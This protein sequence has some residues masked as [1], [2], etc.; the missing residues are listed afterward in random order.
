VTLSYQYDPQQPLPDDVAGLIFDCDGTLVDTMP[1]HYLAWSTIFQELGIHLEERAFYMFAGTPTVKIIEQVTRQHGMT[2]LDYQALAH[3]KEDIFLAHAGECQ[4][5]APVVAVAR[6]EQ[7]RRK[8]AVASGGASYIVRQLLRA[9][10]IEDLF[11]VV[12]G[13]DAPVR[14]KPSPDIFLHTATE[15]GVSAPACVV[16][17]DGHPGFQAARA[18]G[19]RYVDVRPWY[20][21][22]ERIFD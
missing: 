4:A 5:I 1:T 9:E 12:I 20:L 14:G 19:M 17:E 3:R 13:S 16:Y 22:P 6:R 15:L 8:L 21:P 7:G 10:G 18:A 11:P 2:G